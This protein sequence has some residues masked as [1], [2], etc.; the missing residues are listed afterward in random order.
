MY[1][2]GLLKGLWVTL[3]HFWGTIFTDVRRFPR[4][5]ERPD[6]EH[7]TR[8]APTQT[9]GTFSLQYP[10]EKLPMWPRFR[11][12]LMHLR[13]AS[14]GLSR[15]TACGM[16]VKACPHGCITVE[17]EG[18]G[19]DRRASAYTYDVGHCIY[20]RQCVESCPFSAI[21]LSRQY[22]LAMYDKDTIWD[23]NRLLEL[24]DRDGIKETG[25]YW[26]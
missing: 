14:T 1:G 21:E 12:P 5:Y 8:S 23:L 24:G 3:R 20:C 19:K 11:G 9:T 26:S 25:Q 7:P 16:C 2:T 22:E 10:R 13:D 18:K 17:G 4:R 15:C 6:V